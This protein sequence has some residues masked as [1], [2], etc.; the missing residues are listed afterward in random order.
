MQWKDW[1]LL[2]F[3]CISCNVYLRV[4]V[5]FP[6]AYRCSPILTASVLHY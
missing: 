3:R 6:G 5:V 1:M 4:R 2:P